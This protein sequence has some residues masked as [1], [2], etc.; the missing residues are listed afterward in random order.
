[1]GRYDARSRTARHPWSP[2][3]SQSTTFRM[4]AGD[5]PP[6]SRVGD[7]LALADKLDALAGIFAIGQKPTGTRDPFGLRRAA[8]GIVRIVLEHRLE[9]DLIAL[10]DQAVR[11]Q[12]LPEIAARADTI[13]AEIYDYIMERLRAQYLEHAAEN[14]VTTELFD[15]VLATRPASVLDFNARVRALVGFLALPAGASLAAANKRIANILR[16]S[17]PSRRAGLNHS[18]RVD[19]ELLRLPAEG[20]LHDALRSL[21]EAVMAAFEARDYPR[22]LDQLAALKPTVDPT[23]RAGSGQ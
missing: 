17:P 12:P 11:Q 7:A 8:I 9:L 5:T 23:L 6:S 1:M 13:I 19:A 16:K 4:G 22:A 3:Q 10:L 20:A 18:E 21:T 2:T 14:G 15:A